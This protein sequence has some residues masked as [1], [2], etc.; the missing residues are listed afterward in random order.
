VHQ[1][2]D[3]ERLGVPTVWPDDFLRPGRRTRM[4]WYGW[5]DV[6]MLLPI[7]VVT[8]AVGGRNWLLRRN[9]EV[10][11]SSEPQMRWSFLQKVIL[12]ERDVQLVAAI[13]RIHAERREETVDVAVVYGAAHFP[14]VVRTLTARLGYRPQRNGEWLTA[15]DF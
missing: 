2:I 10:D 3:Y 6:V 1:D 13:E 14:V 5:L 11:D 12:E 4:P 8:M 15:I 9:L 7:L